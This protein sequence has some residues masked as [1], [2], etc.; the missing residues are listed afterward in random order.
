MTSPHQSAISPYKNT[1]PF[2][3]ADH[4][5]SSSPQ[6][7]VQDNETKAGIFPGKVIIV[8]TGKLYVIKPVFSIDCGG[9]GVT[10]LSHYFL[11]VKRFLT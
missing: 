9:L 1:H 5:K 11:S 4:L 7:P 2:L 3:Y 6:I 8:A 10:F